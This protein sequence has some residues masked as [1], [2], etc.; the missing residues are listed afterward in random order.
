ML[1]KGHFETSPFSLKHKE[2]FTRHV[3]FPDVSA[4]VQYV[5]LELTG[6]SWYTG[7]RRCV[8]SP[9][10]EGLTLA[11]CRMDKQTVALTSSQ[12]RA[13]DRSEM[14][15][16]PVSSARRI[17]DTLS[18]LQPLNL[19][20]PLWKCILLSYNFIFKNEILLNFL[21]SN[22]MHFKNEHTIQLYFK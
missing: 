7:H 10:G 6:M 18:L 13:Y 15:P 22:F 2:S 9:S 12:S 4:D 19:I 17:Q 11:H 14:S 1:S 16:A 8:H 21:N 5:V 3:N 20:I